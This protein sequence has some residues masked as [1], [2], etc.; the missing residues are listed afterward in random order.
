M[1]SR[2]LGEPDVASSSLSFLFFRKT[3]E[4]GNLVE[5][6]KTTEKLLEIMRIP[7]ERRDA[8]CKKLRHIVQ[9]IDSQRPL[10]KKNSTSDL[11]LREAEERLRSVRDFCRK[12]F[13][14]IMNLLLGIDQISDVLKNFNGW[15]RTPPNKKAAVP[16][17]K[18]RFPSRRGRPRG[19]TDI[20]W[21]L[22]YLLRAL[23]L[24][25]KRYGGRL[26]FYEN[27][28]G[29]DGGPIFQETMALLRPRLP[30][31]VPEPPFQISVIKRIVYQLN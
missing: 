7:E 29:K 2:L 19:T 17:N 10:F 5:T 28:K 9:N 23:F 3:D 6:D 15:T 1:L 22:K 11:R 26:P 14:P 25:S 18:K 4:D 30:H 12:E 31:I 24:L 21:R 20:D 16:S 27:A 13:S 8:F